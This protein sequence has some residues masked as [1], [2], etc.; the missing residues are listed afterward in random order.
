VLTFD[1]VQV[2]QDRRGPD[3]DRLIVAKLT[4]VAQRHAGWR[5][6]TVAETAAAVTELQETAGGRSDLLAEVAAVLLG[7]HE[8]EFDEPKARS[9]AQLCIAAGADESLIPQWIEVGR[10]RAQARRMPLF[11]TAERRPGKHR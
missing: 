7:A 4:G 2:N 5:E 3:P 9:A 11:S 10:R 6:L 8:G 1:P